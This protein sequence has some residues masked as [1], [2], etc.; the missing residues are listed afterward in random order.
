MISF[1][2]LGPASTLHLPVLIPVFFLT[3]QLL[4]LRG[5]G[6]QTLEEASSNNP[7]WGPRTWLCCCLGLIG[8]GLF[9]EGKQP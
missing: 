8:G 5:T 9:L 6:I 7:T 4:F 3:F 1:K 2:D